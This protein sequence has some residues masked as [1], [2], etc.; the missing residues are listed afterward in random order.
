M[1]QSGVVGF[2]A[3]GNAELL[4][5]RADLKAKGVEEDTV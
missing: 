1:E 4:S 2:N 3:Q 5:L